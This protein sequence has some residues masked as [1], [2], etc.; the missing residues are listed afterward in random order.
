MAFLDDQRRLEALRELMSDDAP[1]EVLDGVGAEAARI[2]GMPIGLFSLVAEHTQFFRSHVGLPAALALAQAT[3]RCDSFCKLVVQREEALVVRDAR[4]DARVSKMLVSAYGIVAYV[5]VPV[6]VHGTVIGSVCAIDQRPHDTPT[7]VLR[8]LS[9]LAER[10]SARV[11]ARLR[12]FVA[13]GKLDAR[14]LRQLGLEVSSRANAVLGVLLDAAGFVHT[15]RDASESEHGPELLGEAVRRFR[16]SPAA[17]A[18]VNEHT[19]AFVTIAEC[20]PDSTACAVLRAELRSVHRKLSELRA[21]IRLIDGVRRGVVSEAEA[22]VALS[23]LLELVG[24]YDDLLIRLSSL[25]VM[26]GALVARNA[27]SLRPAPIAAMA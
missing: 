10:V 7:S 11:E 17:L 22:V 8:A 20:L 2:T 18:E 4:T 13:R 12:N 14:E 21:A 6:R 16:A 9:A 3:N 19:Q 1:D 15:L 24:A 27:T 5:G 26:S 23:V 25:Q